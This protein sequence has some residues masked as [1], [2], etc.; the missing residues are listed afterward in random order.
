[1]EGMN[2]PMGSFGNYGHNARAVEVVDRSLK[3]LEP[4]VYSARVQLPAAA[5]YDVAF[6]LESPRVVHCFSLEAK[7]NPGVKRASGPLELEYQDFPTRLT[8]GETP[9][10]RFKL[11]EAS[12][13]RPV[14]GLEDVRVLTY[15]A[16]GRLRA[17]V[18]A[19]EVAEG[20]YEAQPTLTSTGAYYVYVS[21]P[22]KKVGYGELPYRTLSVGA[23]AEKQEA[24]R[25]TP[26]R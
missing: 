1:M 23:R 24:S 3:E 20:V 18:S 19:R 7:E 14:T 21:V 2:A 11:H 4:G 9:R 26:P 15:A 6:L 13:R 10:L 17:E 8:Q 22:S 5:R 25:V 12:T 16:P